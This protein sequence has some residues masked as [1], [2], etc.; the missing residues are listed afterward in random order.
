MWTSQLGEALVSY[1]A[2]HMISQWQYWCTKK[3]EAAVTLVYQ[4]SP[5]GVEYSCYVKT[6]SCSKKLT[7]S[8]VT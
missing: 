7:K 6:F 1:R 3:S 2:F 5:V 4:T 8:L